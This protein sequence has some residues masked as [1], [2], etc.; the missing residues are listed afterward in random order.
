MAIS[1]QDLQ[2]REMSHQTFRN[3]I[4]DLVYLMGTDLDPQRAWERF[5]IVAMELGGVWDSFEDNFVFSNGIRLIGVMLPEG[6]FV[7]FRS[8]MNSTKN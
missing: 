8:D 1:I 2:G 4:I 5:P 3:A 7:G 6:F